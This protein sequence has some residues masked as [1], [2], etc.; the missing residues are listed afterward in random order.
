MNS[1]T[2]TLT[3]SYSKKEFSFQHLLLAVVATLM[4]CLLFRWCDTTT[5]TDTDT[6]TTINQDQQEQSED[7]HQVDCAR[8]IDTSI[9]LIE[10]WVSYLN[11]QNDILLEQWCPTISHDDITWYP[12]VLSDD[13]THQQLPELDIHPM[14]DWSHA[15]FKALANEYKLDPSLIWKYENKYHLTEWMILCIA[16]AETSWGKRGAGINNIGNVGN[17]DSNPRWQSYNWLEE[18][19]DAIG[20]V[21]NNQYLWNTQTLAC[22]SNAWDCQSRDNNW[23]RYAT[24]DGK[25]QRN[26]VNCLSTIYMV[27]INPAIL[28][29]RTTYQPLQVLNVD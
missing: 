17:T 6:D 5:D 26:M 20:R 9:R 1:T 24:S 25:W 15:R 29:F 11:Y 28:S 10:D 3:P 19:L 7:T 13:W 16:I 18:S 4:F 27:D 22:L 21:L 2:P 12:W 23:K 8:A 14:Q